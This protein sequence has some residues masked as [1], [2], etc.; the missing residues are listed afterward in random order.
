MRVRR[1]T[2]R[3]AASR[4]PGRALLA[5]AGVNRRSGTAPLHR[6]DDTA[7]LAL[8]SAL[9]ALLILIAYAGRA[10]SG[11]PS[12]QTLYEWSTAAG[13]LIQDGIVLALVLAIARPK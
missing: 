11:K 7:R 2:R 6:K 3:S 13:G 1:A 5:S 9:M 4:T 8:W 12:A 10:Q